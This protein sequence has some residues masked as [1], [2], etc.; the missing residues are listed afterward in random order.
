MASTIMVSHAN[1]NVHFIQEW[2]K[3]NSLMLSEIP[4]CGSTHAVSHKNMSA[5]RYMTTVLGGGIA[6]SGAV[7]VGHG[8]SS[9]LSI[10]GI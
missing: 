3:V 5:S 10:R 6:P 8:W 9:A 1:I 2:D 7:S 4:P